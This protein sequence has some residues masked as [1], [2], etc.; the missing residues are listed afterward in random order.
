MNMKKVKVVIPDHIYHRASQCGFIRRI[1]KKGI[2]R[3]L[4][5][6][7]KNVRNKTIQPHWLLVSN[8]MYL[9]IFLRQCLS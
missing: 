8:K 7:I 6:V 2:R 1:I 4:H 9:V 3:N 5:F